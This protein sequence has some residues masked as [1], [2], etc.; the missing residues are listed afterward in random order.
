MRNMPKGQTLP[1]LYWMNKQ[2]QLSKQMQ[3]RPGQAANTV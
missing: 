2:I 1:N 3:I